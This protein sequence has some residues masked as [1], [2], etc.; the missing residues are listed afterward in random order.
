MAQKV[1]GA[2]GRTHLEIAMVGREPLVENLRH[3]DGPLAEVQPLRCLLAPVTGVTGDSDPYMRVGTWT[4]HNRTANLPLSDVAVAAAGVKP[5]RGGSFGFLCDE[6]LWG[7][8]RWL[9][10]AGYDTATAAQG[11]ADGELLRR[12][13]VEGRVLLTRDR[14]LA[15]RAGADVVVVALG[16]E[17]LDAG[18]RELRARLGIDWLRAPF[19]RCL[20]DNAALVPASNDARRDLPPKARTLGGAINICPDCGRLYWPGSHVRRMQARLEAWQESFRRMA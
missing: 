18:A 16:S 8:G 6:M 10:A 4:M 13:G 17:D 7:L 3:L 19:T 1:G 20:V 11:L 12:A 5:S 2:V 14:A 15:A 9:R